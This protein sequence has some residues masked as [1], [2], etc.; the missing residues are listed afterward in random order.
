MINE[1]SHQDLYLADD[2]VDGHL[3]IESHT[4]GVIADLSREQTK[5]LINFMMKAQGIRYKDLTLNR[6]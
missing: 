5:T 4:N 6:I 1:Y 2:L 3:Y